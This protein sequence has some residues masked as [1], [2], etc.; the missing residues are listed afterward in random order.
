MS[1]YG[2]ALPGGGRR[3][4]TRWGIIT[5]SSKG[6][7]DDYVTSLQPSFTVNVADRIG[8]YVVPIEPYPTGDDDNTILAFAEHQKALAEQA[9]KDDAHGQ[10]NDPLTLHRDGGGDG[11]EP[12]A[13]RANGTRSACETSDQRSAKRDDRV[14]GMRANVY[15]RKPPGRRRFR[16]KVTDMRSCNI[17]FLLLALF[18]A[19]VWSAGSLPLMVGGLAAFAAPAAATAPWPMMGHDAQQE[20]A[21]TADLR[22]RRRSGRSQ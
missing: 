13:G 10:G 6:M 20:E 1:R 17:R 8:G 4:I 7:T 15:C 21:P 11:G 2:W 16:E 3:R 22:I 9:H 5:V 18:G 19:L 12:T 14:V